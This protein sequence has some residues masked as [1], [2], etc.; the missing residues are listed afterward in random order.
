[1]IILLALLFT[2]VLDLLLFPPLALFMA[3]IK[4]IFAF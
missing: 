2:H 1:M 4:T 3:F